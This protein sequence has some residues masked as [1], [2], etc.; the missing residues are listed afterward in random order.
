MATYK[1]VVVPMQ[2]SGPFSYGRQPD[3]D[4][5][6]FFGPDFAAHF[7]DAYAKSPTL[8]MNLGQSQGSLYSV[9]LSQQV[10][11]YIYRH[12]TGVMA[13][14]IL[15]L[16]T[17]EGL[18]FVFKSKKFNSAIAGVTPYE[19]IS[20]MLTSSQTEI[21]AKSERRGAQIKLEADFYKHGEEGK[22][23]FKE[24]IEQIRDTVQNTLAYAIVHCIDTCQDNQINWWHKHGKLKASLET[25][26][27]WETNYWGCMHNSSNPDAF[28]IMLD[29]LKTSMV[30]YDGAEPDCA[31][32][33]PKIAYIF[34][35]RAPVKTQY[36]IIDG[37][38]NVELREGVN[39]L[40]QFGNLYVF[41][42]TPVQESDVPP[43]DPFS[44]RST[45]GQYY[46]MRARHN[47]QQMET[48]TT[49]S[50]AIFIHEEKNRDDYVPV[51]PIEMYKSCNRWN[52]E[53]GNLK[54]EHFMLTASL[55]DYNPGDAA[56]WWCEPWLKDRRSRDPFIYYDTTCDR[57]NWKVVE[58]FGQM[59]DHFLNT[60]LL[61]GISQTVCNFLS[62]NGYELSRIESDITAVRSLVVASEHEPGTVAYIMKFLDKNRR[63]V[64]NAPE[65]AD[66]TSLPLG[67]VNPFGGFDIPSGS[68]E[69]SEVLFSGMGGVPPFVNTFGMLKSLA[70]LQG[71]KRFEEAAK[72][73]AKGCQAIEAV[74]SALHTVMPDSFMCSTLALPE[75]Q[76]NFCCPGS[77]E[78]AQYANP[79]AVCWNV[80]NA[81]C[82][83][84]FPCVARMSSLTN[85]MGDLSDLRSQC[86]LFDA[87]RGY[88]E[89]ETVI[90]LL[91][92][93]E[94]AVITAGGPRMLETDFSG[95]TELPFPSLN[96]Y[97]LALMCIDPAMPAMLIK[98]AT[99]IVTTTM[100]KFSE[101]ANKSKEMRDQSAIL[102]RSGTVGEVAKSKEMKEAADSLLQQIDVDFLGFITSGDEDEQRNKMVQLVRRT[103]RIYLGGFALATLGKHVWQ[104]QD[105][106][107]VIYD[108]RTGVM[109]PIAD[110][111]RIELFNGLSTVYNAMGS[112]FKKMYYTPDMD[113][114][115]IR[116]ALTRIV[117]DIITCDQS[118]IKNYR[119]LGLGNATSFN[120]QNR[121]TNAEIIASLAG[122][123][124]A[125]IDSVRA[126]LSRV[127]NSDRVEFSEA[128]YNANQNINARTS[129]GSLYYDTPLFRNLARIA[130][131][132]I[133]PLFTALSAGGAPTAADAKIVTDLIKNHSP[134][135][136]ARLDTFLGTNS[137]AA[138]PLGYTLEDYFTED[139]SEIYEREIYNEALKHGLVTPN[140][141]LRTLAIWYNPLLSTE[142]GDKWV[143]GSNWQTMRFFTVPFGASI[144]L[145]NSFAGPSALHVVVSQYGPFP[146][147]FPADP[148]TNF[149]TPIEVGS[150]SVDQLLGISTAVKRR[151]NFGR[152][153]GGPESLAHSR[154]E[155]MQFMSFGKWQGILPIEFVSSPQGREN[156]LALMVDR[157]PITAAL[158]S[159]SN[160]KRVFAT[161]FAM[162]SL[163]NWQ[164]IKKLLDNNVLL[165]FS[166][167]ITRPWIT[168]TAHD[169]PILKM[170][171]DTGATYIG[172]TGCA[173]GMD[174]GTKTMILHYTYHSKPVIYRP[175]NVIKARDAVISQV[176][177]GFGVK[178]ATNDMETPLCG[179]FSRTND[180]IGMLCGYYDS[181]VDASSDAVTSPPLRNPL[182]LFGKFI[183]IPEVEGNIDGDGEPHIGSTC[184]YSLVFPN[185]YRAI[186]ATLADRPSTTSMHLNSL[187][188]LG[189]HYFYNPETGTFSAFVMN[190]GHFSQTATMPGTGKVRKGAA[191]SY[192]LIYTPRQNLILS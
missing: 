19:G 137:G 27:D 74:A 99:D 5:A 28:G 190:T 162:C 46:V 103:V 123:A 66:P 164:T 133:A 11:S 17:M 34:K 15:P 7:T 166:A 50:Q 49:A 104:L 89:I 59:E 4:M 36:Q 144:G 23:A 32:I 54:N 18:N 161:A 8:A 185:L 71:S 129:N 51:T 107:V 158:L 120:K 180:I 187:C 101:I 139:D 85:A 25:L 35:D 86:V 97:A 156:V 37:K 73:A 165:P 63:Y 136:I 65:S 160:V 33:P 182:S 102:A 81:V 117:A 90:D 112:G 42:A 179:D 152:T 10:G 186:N 150:D 159:P 62:R 56:K 126:V 163:R 52:L 78:S 95:R 82:G 93:S 183:N 108:V 21:Y 119:T 181:M 147:I 94:L 100:Q 9:T 131:N 154:T 6:E 171:L 130:Y 45:V 170:G 148:V 140:T 138:V 20:R 169:I 24:G 58:Y 72:I 96:A 44:H 124:N 12:R 121:L 177:C 153:A 188:F 155:G 1:D 118:E 116:E 41:E 87:F 64:P 31:L 106:R 77:N 167:V 111:S 191:P 43:Y 60:N 115:S 168:C 172:D 145:L 192:P 14:Q 88:E 47:L 151:S 80:F 175:Q 57:D 61:A 134:N 70:A 113:I 114:S 68:D 16:M 92:T 48:Y 146:L 132:V 135:A 174:V 69:E 141:L 184:Y 38:Q 125:D 149:A 109:T 53:T 26:L 98:F 13:S 3:S 40:A 83:I 127:V 143:N 22:K 39:A 157:P 30:T 76:R 105:G 176:L 79:T 110:G 2:N 128:F 173:V 75:W 84:S 55:N 91:T 189:E 142:D 178:F 67:R 29:S 122:T